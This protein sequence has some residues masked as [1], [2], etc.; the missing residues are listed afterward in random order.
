VGSP[1]R[2]SSTARRTETR[3]PF[4]SATGLATPYAFRDNDRRERLK[5][6]AAGKDRLQPTAERPKTLAPARRILRDKNQTRWFHL[7]CRV[8]AHENRLH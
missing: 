2:R 7:D 8:V 4:E 5:V 1:R 3:T 6:H